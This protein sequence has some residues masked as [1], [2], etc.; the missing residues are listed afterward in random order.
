M[1]SVCLCQDPAGSTKFLLMRTIALGCLV[2]GLWGAPCAGV[3]QPIDRAFAGQSNGLEQTASQPCVSPKVVHH[4]RPARIR[5]VQSPPCSLVTGTN[6]SGN[7]PTTGATG[8]STS[9]T[10]GASAGA[11]K[12]APAWGEVI[13][14]LAEGGL[15]LV[16]L[17]FAVFAFL[18][19]TLLGLK[20]YDDRANQ[21]R[22]KLRHSLYATSVTVII[23]SLLTVCAFVTMATGGKILTAVTVCLATLVVI[24]ISGIVF[25]LS[26]DVYREDKEET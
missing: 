17:A 4:K 6:S 22:T 1:A 10:A 9:G 19:V 3:Q 14:A 12:P 5:E 21:L 20:E 11:R 7:S 15:A 24:M 18:Y 25:Y 8:S 13:K 23:S 26:I 2:L 16:S